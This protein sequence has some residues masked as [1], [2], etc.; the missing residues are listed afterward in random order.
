M[1]FVTLP[2]YDKESPS[3]AHDEIVATFRSYAIARMFVDA[4]TE[5]YSSHDAKFTPKVFDEEDLLP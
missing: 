2:I 3:G 4:W 5:K 1:V